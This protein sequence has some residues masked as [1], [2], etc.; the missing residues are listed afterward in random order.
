MISDPTAGRLGDIGKTIGV[1]RQQA[2]ENARQDELMS[3]KRDEA[4]AA[5][6]ASRQD[7]ERDAAKEAREIEKRKEQADAAALKMKADLLDYDEAKREDN[8]SDATTL[9]AWIE[10]YK[11]DA[12]NGVVNPND[13]NSHQEYV[14][15]RLTGVD[16]PDVLK[17][18]NSVPPSSYP[19][20]QKNAQFAISTY[21]ESKGEERFSDFA[22]IPGTELY[23]QKSSKTGK[24]TNIKESI[25]GTTKLGNSEFERHISGLLARNLITQ[26]KADELIEQRAEGFAGEMTKSQQSR[27]SETQQDRYNREKT[28]LRKEYNTGAEHFKNMGNTF[29]SAIAAMDSGDSKLSEI[30]LN[31][32]LSQLQ[33]SDVRAFQMYGEFDKGFGNLAQRI[34]TMASKFLTGTRTETEKEEIKS[35]ITKFNETY[36]KPAQAKLRNRYRRLAIDQGKDPFEVVPPKN[37]KDILGT[38]LLNNKEKAKLIKNFF[39]DWKPPK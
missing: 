18:L 33:D 35:V 17:I 25:D 15:S 30:M 11:I 14:Q 7:A 4:T 3:M 38:T 8:L 28:A 2:I 16:D 39:P 36:V 20:A 26:E 1:N 37:V 13:P 32:S 21:T 9:N 5:A 24:F 12:Q 6:E 10:Q 19:A 22:K 29:D 23:G 27:L 31:Q 34:S